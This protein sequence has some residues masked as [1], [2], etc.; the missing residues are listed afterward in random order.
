MRI[1]HQAMIGAVAVMVAMSGIVSV[2]RELPLAAVAVSSF[3]DEKFTWGDVSVE[4]SREG[5]R[6]K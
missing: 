3:A 6:E 2:M 5:K 4:I 1:I